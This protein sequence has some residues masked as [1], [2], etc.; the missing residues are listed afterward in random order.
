MPSSAGTRNG[1]QCEK[2]GHII[3]TV[4]EVDGT[5][6]FMLGCML[7]VCTGLMQSWMTA[8]HPVFG[9][10]TYR[11]VNNK[12]KDPNQPL[13]LQKIPMSEF[14]MRKGMQQRRGKMK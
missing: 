3:L 8:V 7:P 5:T 6:P 2:C 4:N 13:V 12:T 9:E 10:P 14:D 11:W 1:Y